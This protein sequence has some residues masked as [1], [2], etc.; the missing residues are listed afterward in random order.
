MFRNHPE[1]PNLDGGMLFRAHGQYGSYYDG[2]SGKLV[3]AVCDLCLK[4]AGRAGDV[5]QET[6]AEPP[7]P[8]ISK[9]D[10]DHNPYREEEHG[11]NPL[12]E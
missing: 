3:I 1:Y 6:P 5:I 10:P 11:K 9:W 4:T 7:P 8:E 2:I 12:H